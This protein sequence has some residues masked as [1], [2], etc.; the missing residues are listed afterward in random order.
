MNNSNIKNQ[1]SLLLID[2]ELIGTVLYLIAII[3]SILLII[4]QRNIILEKEPL[5]ETGEF[6]ILV[7][8]NRVF[9]LLLT[10]WFL[11]INYKTYKYIQESNNDTKLSKLQLFSSFILVIGAIIGLYIANSNNVNQSVNIENPEI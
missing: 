11:Y 9:I 5:F 2:S 7:L 1:E 8:A 10:L 4:N 6:R 3:I